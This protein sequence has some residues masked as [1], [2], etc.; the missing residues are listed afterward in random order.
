VTPPTR[1]PRRR[2]SLPSRWYPLHSSPA[3][4]RTHCA[5]KTDRF[6]F[7]AWVAMQFRNWWSKNPIK[8]TTPS[9]GY[10]KHKWRKERNRSR[11]RRENGRLSTRGAKA[12]RK[13]CRENMRLWRQ[14]APTENGRGFLVWW[15]RRDLNPGP[16]DYACHYGFRRLLRVRGLD[17]TFPLRAGRLVSTPSPSCRG[18][19]R[20][21]LVPGE[22]AFTEFDQFYPSPGFF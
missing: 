2:A 12:S 1:A 10:P 14:K 9:L 5:K 13:K 16:K 18:L 22:L 20:Y 6:R 17:Y 19:A 15:A 4:S 3:L 11:F 7:F 8:T 21:W